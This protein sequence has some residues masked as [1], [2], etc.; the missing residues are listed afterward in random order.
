[1][2]KEFCSSKTDMKMSNIFR[3]ISTSTRLTKQNV[4][5][6]VGYSKILEFAC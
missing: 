4:T 6:T 2:S 5:N 1:M 3:D